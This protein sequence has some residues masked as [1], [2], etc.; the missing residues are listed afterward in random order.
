MSGVAVIDS[1]NYELNVDTGFPQNAFILDETPEGIL[2]GYASIQTAT[3]LHPDPNCTNISRWSA[4]AGTRTLETTDP[5]IGSTYIR[6]VSTQSVQDAYIYYSDNRINYANPIDGETL[7]VKTS[8]TYRFSAYV[9]NVAG[10]TRSI[11][12]RVQQYDGSGGAGTLS[13]VASTSLAPGSPW[14]L[15]DGTFTT[16]STTYSIQARIYNQTTSRNATNTIDIDAVCFT[17]TSASRPYFDGADSVAYPDYTVM[18]QQWNG[19]PNVS[20][21]TITWGLTSSYVNSDY[22]LDGSIFFANIMQSCTRISIM[23]GREDIGDQFSA[24][25]MSFTIQDTSGVFNPFDQN[26]P[27][28]DAN[29]DIPGLAPLREVNLKRYDVDNNLQTIFSG[30]VVNYNYN[31]ALGGLDSV[32]VYCADQFYLLAQT[33]L[34]AYNPSA[35]TSGERIETILSLPEV[36]FPAAQRDIA[37]GTV[38]LGHDASYN[39]SAGTNALAY[40]TEINQ[41]AELGRVFM[42]REGNFTFQNRQSTLVGQLVAEFTDDGTGL[43]YDGVGITFEADA[44]VNRVVVTGL[45]GTSSTANDVPSQTTYFI[46]NQTIS[47]SLLHVAGEISDAA[48]YLLNP[49]PEPRYTSVETKYLMLTD[50]Q[51]DALTI[52]DI[53]DSIIILKTFPSGVGTTTFGQELSIEGIQH[54]ITFEQGHKITYFTGDEIIYAVLI[55]DNATYGTLDTTNA[56]R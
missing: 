29:Q 41:T 47:G 21:S 54:E 9:R 11:S 12:L 8:T 31:F 33:E 28:Y 50:A 45:N 15:L 24:G 6:T 22:V 17:E 26:S 39:I 56:L 36:D 40:I 3:N 23:R 32:T 43:P 10:T 42:S 16:Q 19:A 5:Y 20:T 14:T 7:V 2:A 37:T 46:Q 13:I 55:L 4:P 25:T 52:S 30:Y 51:R 49:E 44:V 34:D 53:G 1:G 48:T 27:Y 35:E 38:N 18:E